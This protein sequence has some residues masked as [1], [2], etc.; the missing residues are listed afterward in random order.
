M[1]QIHGEA[2][3][4]TDPSSKV[5][6]ES[7]VA[8]CDSLMWK[9]L[10]GYYEQMAADAWSTNQVPM[11]VSSNAR[12]CRDYANMVFNYMIDYYSRI[13]KDARKTMYFIE[14]GAGHGRFTFLFIRMILK[15]LPLMNAYGFPEKPFKFVFTDIAQGNIDACRR[16]PKMQDFIEEGWLDFALFDAE[17]P[18][19]K[20]H[21]LISDA[22]IPRASP[23][24]VVSNYV[25]DS[26]KTDAIQIVPKKFLVPNDDGVLLSVVRVS[27]YSDRKESN[28]V[29]PSILNRATFGWHWKPIQ[30]AGTGLDDFASEATDEQNRSQFILGRGFGTDRCSNKCGPQCTAGCLDREAVDQMV[31]TH[32]ADTNEV[33]RIRE[34]LHDTDSWVSPP[35]WMLDPRMMRLV[36]G[37]MKDAVALSSPLSITIP[38]GALSVIQYLVKYSD[39]QLMLLIGDKGYA[40]PINMI[41]LRHPHIAIHGT[42]SF[43][44]NF[45][46]LEKFTDVSNGFH[47]NTKYKGS[48]HISCFC[49]PQDATNQFLHL[50][51]VMLSRWEDIAPETLVTIMQE[52][53]EVEKTKGVSLRY[54]NAVVRL[55][56]HDPDALTQFSKS[57]VVNCQPPEMT[58]LH[59]VDMLDDLREI[60]S[61]WF[62]LKADD[63][64]PETLAHMCVKMGKVHEAI[65]YFNE[66]IKTCPNQ[67]TAGTLTNLAGCLGAVQRIDEGQTIL[68]QCLEKYPGFKPAVA[69]LTYLEM[70]RKSR[71]IG[72]IGCGSFAS[73]FSHFI[74]KHATL[75]I[76][77]I[78][79]FNFEVVKNFKLA[80]Q[81]NA[82]SVVENGNWV[83]EICENQ[84]ISDVILD[85]DMS[86]WKLFLSKLWANGKNVLCEKTIGIS[87]KELQDLITQ[88]NSYNLFRAENGLP[89]LT[90]HVS[91][92]ESSDSYISPSLLAACGDNIDSVSAGVRIMYPK[93]VSAS[94]NGKELALKRDLIRAIN[95]CCKLTN[96]QVKYISCRMTKDSEGQ[97]I[98]LNGWSKMT[99]KHSDSDYMMIFHVGI[100]T[101][102]SPGF[103]GTFH[104]KQGTVE[105]RS[106]TCYWKTCSKVAA[107]KVES[108]KS[109]MSSPIQ[110]SINI[111][112]SGVHAIE[113]GQSQAMSSGSTDMLT[114][115]VE[116]VNICTG[117][118]GSIE[119]GGLTVTFQ[120]SVSMENLLPECEK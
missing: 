81:L 9:W 28:P 118:E 41:G 65:F 55:S 33:A 74:S 23:L 78:F 46:V 72:V 79:G 106:A 57:L 37:Y 71:H 15:M 101:H 31:A 75:R 5:V 93:E 38:V 34:S 111:F 113:T 100:T 2:R 48:F 49:F 110:D 39:N 87:Y 64:L 116:D 90:W 22:E 7:Q 17:R 115:L 52:S 117:I 89:I 32:L 3:V 92:R 67:V 86:L 25:M 80:H 99:L 91:N 45:N 1:A 103:F 85:V 120:K 13:K 29:D 97:A 69:L 50:G 54:M 51:S 114:S 27:L 105:L 88:F 26:L 35:D 20:I 68:R 96:A 76:V 61:N 24:V 98:G 104:S 112:L 60:Y 44:C 40:S 10:C 53:D 43:G 56:C 84:E 42:I 58:A 19:E 12:V 16:H 108:K 18:P 102:G 70:S 36:K 11:F 119:R 73:D 21:L 94:T 62:K 59:E 77:K 4:E 14:I 30:T 109:Y 63:D 82:A 66:F 83:Q 95:L 107:T 47:F 8:L 6:L